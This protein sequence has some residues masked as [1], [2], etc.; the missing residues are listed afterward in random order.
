MNNDRKLHATHVLHPDVESGSGKPQQPAP[1]VT[2]DC[3][4]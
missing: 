2:K 3:Y 4:F 1:F